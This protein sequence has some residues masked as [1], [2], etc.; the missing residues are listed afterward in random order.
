VYRSA[1]FRCR[2]SRMT[3]YG[4]PKV[5]TLGS[6]ALGPGS[7]TCPPTPNELTCGGAAGGLAA[8]ARVQRCVCAPAAP[9]GWRRPGQGLA[10]GSRALPAARAPPWTCGI[11]AS[12]SLT[13][14]GPSLY[15]RLHRLCP[16]REGT[17]VHIGRADHGKVEFGHL[18]CSGH[19]AGSVRRPVCAG[20]VLVL[21]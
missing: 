18:A 20:D 7:F 13:V 3:A 9:A 11:V 5:Y 12:V 1:S 2:S 6:V 8:A 14:P 10:P 17:P 21:L 15:A 16:H 4:V 19:S